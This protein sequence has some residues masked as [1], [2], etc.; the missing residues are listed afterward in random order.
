VNSIFRSDGL[1]LAFDG[2]YLMNS[3]GTQ[4]FKS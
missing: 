4:E 3:Q 1:S 2:V